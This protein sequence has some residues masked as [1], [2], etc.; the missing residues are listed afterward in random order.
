M[1]SPP[2][3]REFRIEDA[4]RLA[5]VMES[6]G[7]KIYKSWR[8][9]G[10]ICVTPETIRPKYVVVDGLGRVCIQDPLLSHPCTPHLTPLGSIT[11]NRNWPEQVRSLYSNPVTVETPTSELS[12]V[13]LEA[14][15]SWKETYPKRVEFI[16]KLFVE[17][18]GLVD[19]Y[20][21]IDPAETV[22][23]P[24]V[25]RTGRIEGLEVTPEGDVRWSD[26]KKVAWDLTRPASFSGGR[27]HQRISIMDV[28]LCTFSG[29]PP[30]DEHR[31]TEINV[32]VGMVGICRTWPVSNLEWSLKRPARASKLTEEQV[33]WIFD[34]FSK[35]A[36]QREI[37]E[38]LHVAS[39]S[40][41]GVLRGFSH[42]EKDDMRRAALEERSK[43]GIPEDTVTEYM[44]ARFKLIDKKKR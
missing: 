38:Y 36:T 34:E 25:G 44:R 3:W 2:K 31:A 13:V 16:E 24:A 22:W 41:S 19:T 29:P 20:V 42:P 39:T 37:S 11:W 26:G 12:P 4:K 10:E 15:E 9:G 18:E 33:A 32:D 21:N 35:G 5:D 7:I 17:A 43:N 28:I 23:T 1:G 14:I 27:R 8:A 6:S 40:V 30:S